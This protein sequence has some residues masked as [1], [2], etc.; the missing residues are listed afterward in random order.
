M[1]LTLSIDDATVAKA[2]KVAE[3]QGTSLQALVRG[4]LRGV[5]GDDGRDLALA[6]L[7]A[8]WETGP[9]HSGGYVWR[10]SDAYEGRAVI[11]GLVER[12]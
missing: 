8:G 1:N 12:P 4:Y 9:G 10:R 2:R 11:E 5:A 7:Q 6:R 3:A